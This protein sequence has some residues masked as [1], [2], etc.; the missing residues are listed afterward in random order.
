MKKLVCGKENEMSRKK[1]YSITALAVIVLCLLFVTFLY[2]LQLRTIAAS[3]DTVLGDVNDDHSIDIRDTVRIKRYEKDSTQKV[4]LA[5]DMNTDGKI[6]Y[7][8]LEYHMMLVN[9]NYDV[10][11]VKITVTEDD[12]FASAYHA[13]NGQ[14]NVIYDLQRPVKTDK[15]LVFDVVIPELSTDTAIFAEGYSKDGTLLQETV[16]LSGW[17]TDA[18]RTLSFKA[19]ADV[20]TIRLVF[21]FRGVEA[22]PGDCAISNIRITDAIIVTKYNT[23]HC[24]YNDQI[25]QWNV[26]YDLQQS[27]TKGQRLTFDIEIPEL[28]TD[29]AVFAEGY[30]KEGTLILETAVLSGWYTDAKRTLSFEASADVDYVR[31]TIA[32]RGRDTYPGHCNITDVCTTND[33]VV[34]KYNT[35]HCGYNAQN[36]QWNV[37]YDLQQPVMTGQIL[38]FDVKIPELTTDTAIYAEGYNADNVLV[39]DSVVLSGW[40]TDSVRTLTYMVTTDLAYIRIVFSHR[41]TTIYPGNNVISNVMVSDEIKVTQNNAFLSAYNEN[42][43]QWNVIYDLKFPMKPG[44]TMTFDVKLPELATDTAIYAEGYGVDDTVVQDSV[45]LSG[46]KVDAERTLSFEATTEITYVRIVFSHRGISEYPGD[47]VILGIH[48]SNIITVTEDKCFSS[49]YNPN[50]DQWNVIYDMRVPLSA[51]QILT[52][53]LNIPV[54]TTDTAIWA[55]GYGANDEIVQESV[56][57]SGWLKDTNR[58]LAFEATKN[59]DYVRLIIG[60]RGISEYPG[61]SIIANIGVQN[62]N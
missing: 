39:Q 41:E 8:D 4:S 46:W 62:A 14:W 55:E 59:I 20:D 43:D 2:Q 60:H 37:I 27:V 51:G 15:T 53:E 9:G 25:D 30:S 42:S 49:A 19:T 32:F 36:D 28:T 35:F 10:N 18:E 33:I 16:V 45:V 38:S 47:R 26:I 29:T 24:G 48:T 22:Y 21:S 50:S 58:E 13:Q 23:F 34:T 31:I 40:C 57:L 17:C 11:K 6:S 7:K 3:N 1:K 44:Q 56:V 12:V 61:N 54:L 52:F 5:G